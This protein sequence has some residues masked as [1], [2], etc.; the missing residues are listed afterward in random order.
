[1]GVTDRLWSLDD[2][3]A[4]IDAMAHTPAKRGPYKKRA[5]NSN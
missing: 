5:L 3:V 4:K 1:A 2:V